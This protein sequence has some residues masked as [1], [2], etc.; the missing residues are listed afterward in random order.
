MILW[1]CGSYSGLSQPHSHVCITAGL[2]A[3]G[4]PT[5]ASFPGSGGGQAAGEGLGCLAGCPASP[6][7][8]PVFGQADS[9]VFLG[10]L[11]AP[12]SETQGLFK[13][14]FA[15]GYVHLIG[16][17]KL[18]GWKSRPALDGGGLWPCLRPTQAERCAAQPLP[19]R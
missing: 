12:S 15:S 3:A 6:M 5:M 1:V 4:R 2:L 19:T 13:L 9:G 7:H 11:S 16:K 10:G 17:P 8:G 14:L 18:E